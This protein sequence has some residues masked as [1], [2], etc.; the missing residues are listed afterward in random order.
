MLKSGESIR[1]LGKKLDLFHLQERAPGMVFWHPKGVAAYIKAVGAIYAT[2]QLFDN[3][4]QEVKRRKIV[5][6]CFW[7]KI[8]HWGKYQ[9]EMFTTLFLRM[10]DYAVKRDEL[11][12]SYSRFIIRVE[13]VTVI[14]RFDGRIC[15]CHRN[16][17]SGALHWV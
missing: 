15:S 2:K 4:Y 14:C 5:D 11:A 8:W 17:A 1:K 12:V 13:K 7:E 9:R 16:E 10:R 3:N 6:R